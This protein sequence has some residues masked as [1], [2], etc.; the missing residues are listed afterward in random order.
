MT[1]K[2]KSFWTRRSNCM[3]FL[4]IQSVTYFG[5]ATF[6]SIT[7]T[8]AFVLPS[9]TTRARARTTT[10]TSSALTR[11]SVRKITLGF[12]STRNNNNNNKVNDDDKTACRVGLQ[13]DAS[14][15]LTSSSL[16]L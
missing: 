7:T 15:T 9:P 5:V 12:I 3:I 6:L 16:S 10:T 1:N 14:S 8:N 4:L 2:L 11:V 13:I